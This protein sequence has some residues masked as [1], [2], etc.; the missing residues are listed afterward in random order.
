MASC[1]STPFYYKK[2]EYVD[3]KRKKKTK[4]DETAAPVLYAKL[5]YSDKTKKILSMF[6]TKGKENVNPFNYSQSVL[7]YKNGFD[8]RRNLHK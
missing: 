8:I 6:K 3:K 4:R 2:I 5:I 1:M 7:L